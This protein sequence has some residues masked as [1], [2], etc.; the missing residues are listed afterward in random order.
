[1]KKD[2]ILL[3][4]LIKYFDTYNRSDGKSQPTL[5]WYNGTLTMFLGWL[6]EIGRPVSL[7]VKGFRYLH[8]VVWTHKRAQSTAFASILIDHDAGHTVL[9]CVSCSDC[10]FLLCRTPS[11]ARRCTLTRR[12]KHQKETVDRHQLYVQR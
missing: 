10:S 5:R 1:M 7:G 11:K 12:V 8:E 2:N 4:D 6:T 9:L 3:Q